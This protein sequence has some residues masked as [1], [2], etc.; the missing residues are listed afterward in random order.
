MPEIIQ[1][2]NTIGIRLRGIIKVTFRDWHVRK[3]INF[4]NLLKLIFLYSAS[5]SWIIF[6]EMDYSKNFWSKAIEGNFSERKFSFYST[7][8]RIGEGVL[9]DRLVVTADKLAYDYSAFKFPESLS[10][11]WLTSHFYKASTSIVNYIFKPQFNLALRFVPGHTVNLA[12]RDTTK[13]ESTA[14]G[15]PS[16]GTHLEVAVVSLAPCCT[17]YT[18]G[19]P[20]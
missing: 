10:H 18:C 11:F 13:L 15:P 16:N 17:P 2:I 4:S 14:F 9:Y 19:P 5:L 7:R 8:D 1:F 20:R 12:S 6:F 3:F